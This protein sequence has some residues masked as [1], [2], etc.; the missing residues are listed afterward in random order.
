MRTATKATLVAVLSCVNYD[1]LF[2]LIFVNVIVTFSYLMSSVNSNYK[3]VSCIGKALI[4]AYKETT[5]LLE[6]TLQQEGLHPEVIRQTHREEYQ[7][8]SP[9]YL[10]LLNHR[11]AW[12]KAALESQPTLIIEADFVPVKYFGELP[13]PFPSDNSN[14]GVAWIYTCASQIYSIS[15]EGYA[16]GFSTSTVA[17]IITSQAARYLLELAERVKELKTPY[18]YSSWDSEIDGFLRSKKLINY[19]PFRNYGEHGGQP[20]P[21][22]SQHGLSST[23]RADVLYRDLAFMPLYITIKQRNFFYFLQ[24]RLQGRLKGI[25]RLLTGRFLRLEILK[26]SKVPLRML[27]FAV[28]RQLSTTL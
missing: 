18:V 9:S 24:I 17:Y 1:C 11:E 21:E 6:K 13:L 20:N 8:F 19:I 10:C 5:E 15:S 14:T 25:A 27:K 7:D 16:D 28:I 2:I 26:G 23:H 3:L 4:I 12:Q 22:H